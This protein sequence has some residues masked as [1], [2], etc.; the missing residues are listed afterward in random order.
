MAVALLAGPSVVI[1]ANDIDGAAAF[2]PLAP[3]GPRA[4]PAR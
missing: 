3:L 1:A 4:C 2:P